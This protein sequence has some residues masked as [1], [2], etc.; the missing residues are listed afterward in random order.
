MLCCAVFCPTQV[1]PEALADAHG[2]KRLNARYYILKQIIPALMRILSLVG[3]D[4]MRWFEL[5]NKTD[6]S[7]PQKRTRSALPLPAEASTSAAS[8]HTIDAFYLSRH[9]AVCD[10]QT[11]MG[12]PVCPAC[13]ADPQATVAGLEARAAA[14]EAAAGKALA[15]CLACGGGGGVERQGSAWG[16]LE[17]IVCVSLDCA[18]YFERRKIEHEAATARELADAGLAS[19]AGP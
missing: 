11:Y 2:A 13:L 5:M 12:R 18:L 14:L 4:C 19:L 10:A 1:R 17:R 6:R 16:G 3:A 9:C 7:L 15:V 8:A